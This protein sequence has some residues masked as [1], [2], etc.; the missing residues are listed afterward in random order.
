MAC[1]MPERTYMVVDPR[2]DHSLRAPR[3][4]LTLS[5]GVPNACGDCHA[6]RG[7]QWA[8]DALVK[9]FGEPSRHWGEVLHA[10]RQG[11]FGAW[12]ELVAMARDPSAPGIA[13]ATALTLLRGDD[14]LAVRTAFDEAATDADPL[15]RRAALEG[16]A[17][18]AGPAPM[19][20]L[21]AL[22][23][24]ALS[25]R[26]EAARLAAL[27]GSLPEGGEEELLR[28]EEQGL[29]DRPEAHVRRGAVLY[30]LKRMDQAEGAYRTALRL[31]PGHVP[32]WINLAE[33]LRRTAGEEK[34][35]AVLQEATTKQPRA[36]L[37]H[38]ALGLSLTRSRQRAEATL[39]FAEAARLEP[40]DGDYALAHGLGLQA[41]GRLEDG[42]GVLESALERV[43]GP[44]DLLRA[45]VEMSSATKDDE[46]TTRHAVHLRRLS[47][48]DEVA[49]EW[50]ERD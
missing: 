24:R 44:E 6:D 32:A 38:Y 21:E 7:A 31:D 4:D 41:E 35:E 27:R 12:E 47:P 18:L 37:L 15:V 46:R 45:L 36:A 14:R 50:L 20:A 26:V 49:T 8:E 3:P 9:W 40:G 30:A 2:R 1:H 23:D 16:M 48:W 39:A 22:T 17:S 5:L 34:A 19:A 25:V 13:R 10:G 29:G 33:L 43:E 11:T 28:V 42:I